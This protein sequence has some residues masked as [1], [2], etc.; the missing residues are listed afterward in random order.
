[1]T[2]L[3]TPADSFGIK[4]TVHLPAKAS[5]EKSSITALSASDEEP[6]AIALS[7]ILRESDRR[8]GLPPRPHLMTDWLE[9]SKEPGAGVYTVTVVN[10]DVMARVIPYVDPVG[11]VSFQQPMFSGRRLD[12]RPHHLRLNQHGQLI[13]GTEW[14]KSSLMQCAIAY[15]TLCAE[16]NRDVVVWIGGV[17]KLY[18]LVMGWTEPFLDKGLRGPIDWIAHGPEDTLKMLAAAMRVGRFRQ[19]V[20]TH[21]RGGWPA[22]LLILDEVAFL[23]ERHVTPIRFDGIPMYPDAM[24]TDIVRGV[25]SAKVYAMLANQ[26]DVHATFGDKGNTLQAMMQYS[27]MFRINDDSSHGRQLGKAGY[28]LKMPRCKGEY[29]IN[30]ESTGMPVR[31]KA[32][33]PQ[34]VD[35]DKDVLHDG[36]TVADIAWSRRGMHTGTPHELDERSAVA[37]GPDYQNRHKMVTE[38]FLDYLTGAAFSPAYYGPT[39]SQESGQESEHVDE[40]VDPEQRELT[41][42]ESDLATSLAELRAL[43]EPIPEEMAEWFAAY[44]EQYGKVT[45]AATQPGRSATVSSLVGRQSRKDRVLAIIREAPE[46]PT[47]AAILVRLHEMGDTAA[48]AQTVTNALTDLVTPPRGAPLAVRNPDNSYRAL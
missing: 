31:V 6:L 18:D 20:R 34:T 24:L 40:S 42:A 36:L 7:E 11:P 38:E 17:Q 43:G 13:G 37:A 25:T 15:A 45:P 19:S 2:A 44:E 5:Q 23:L 28:Q 3:I 39:G 48:T 9:I 14:G 46:P 16:Q 47:R 26:H 12:G 29:W 22:I 27:A 1:M 10:Q 41:A 32:P 30:D 33:Y 8:R 35:P 21:Q 4:F